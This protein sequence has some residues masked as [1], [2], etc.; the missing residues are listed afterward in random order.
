LYLGIQ[1]ARL[2]RTFYMLPRDRFTE[3]AQ[4]AAVRAIE[5]MQRYGHDQMDTEHILLALLEQPEGAIPLILEKLSV[6]PEPIKKRLDDVLRT[7][8]KTATSAFDASKVS[9]TPRIFHMLELAAG[10]SQRASAKISTEQLFLGLLAEHDT[11]VAGILS[12]AGIT[13]ERVQ[14][15]LQNP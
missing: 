12:E 11:A 9:I 7:S 4:D 15:I 5:I 8:P 2:E 14:Q 6:E 10:E 3:H 13:V 1:L